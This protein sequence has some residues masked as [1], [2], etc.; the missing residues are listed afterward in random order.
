MFFPIR[1]SIRP[2]RTPY[3]NYALIAA[4]VLVFGLQFTVH[5]MTHQLA[6]RAWVGDAVLVPGQWRFWQFLTYAFLHANVWHVFGNMFFLYLFGNNVNSTLGHAKYISFYLGGAVVSGIGHT[7]LHYHSLI[8]TLGAS[9]AVAAV[10]GAYLVLFPQTLVTVLYWFLFIG[11]IEIPALWFIG[12][13]MILIDNVLARTSGGVAYDA[14][15][16]GYIYGIGI[17]VL[18]LGVGLI[19]GTHYDLWAMIHQ[20]NRRRRYRDAVSEGYDPF[21]IP[22]AM[23]RKP[24]RARAVE[25]TPAE[26]EKASAVQ[27]ARSS[28]HEWL[29]Q[30]N[31]SA[32]AQSYL[33][34]MRLD[35][36]QI[37]PRQALLDIANQLAST[38]RHSDAAQAYEQFLGHYQSY[39]YIGQVML[40][41]GLLYSR[42]LDKPDQAIELLRQ[43]EAK[44]SHPEQ[45]KVCR[46]ELRRLGH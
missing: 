40:M 39:E 14:H 36:Q 11:T 45:E 44:L 15:V 9:G 6:L 38:G 24:V 10:T 31:L 33:S 46:D 26:I 17:M 20:W 41:L 35:D 25:K 2:R 29:L 18:C 19:Q 27:S 30:R 28:I 23:A 42:Y 34:L 5:P 32:A 16:A 8:P 21:G 22:P 12:L 4:N 37:L 7:L 13:K 43:A 1:T 3:A